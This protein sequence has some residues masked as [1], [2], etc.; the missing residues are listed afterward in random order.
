[1]QSY[2]YIPH[3]VYLQHAIRNIWQLDAMSSFRKEII[4]P[5]GTIEIIF[6]FNERENVEATFDGQQHSSVNRCFINGFNSCPILLNLPERHLF[7]G[8]QFQ[9]WAIKN[10]LKIPPYEFANCMIDLTLL[11]KFF[12]SLWH[13][14][15]DQTEFNE[16]VKIVTEWINRQVI[17]NH[18]QE[19]L[20]NLF[21]CDTNSAVVT[22]PQLATNLCYSPRHLS[23]KLY[24]LTKMNTEEVL[25][26]KKFLHA[27]QL[28]HTSDLSLTAIAHQSNFTDQSHF[29]KSFKLLAKMT[30]GEYR[31]NKSFLQGHLYE[32]VR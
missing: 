30:P 1:M 25:L 5:K 31:Q 20:L 24:E 7:F 2:Y 17:S 23:R 12:N 32:N 16:R 10:L 15:A 28:I 19:K 8:I 11:D 14:L 22:V 3:T 13:Q 4:I 18:P 27:V 26:Y 29:I 6:N 21:L 9:P